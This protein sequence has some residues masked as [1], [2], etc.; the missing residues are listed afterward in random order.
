MALFNP[1]LVTIHG[2]PV[3]NTFSKSRSVNLFC[4]FITP[5]IDLLPVDFPFF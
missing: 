2:S 3:R 1:R 5:E 4:F